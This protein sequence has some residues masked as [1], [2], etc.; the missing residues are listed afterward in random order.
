MAID[1]PQLSALR[2]PVRRYQPLVP[3]AIALILGILAGEYSAPA[4]CRG[5]LPPVRLGC[6]GWCCGYEETAA[7]GCW[8]Q[9]WR[10]LPAPAAWYHG[11]DIDP[12]PD[13]IAQLST[14]YS[15]LVAIEG[16][17]VHSPQQTSPPETFS[18]RRQV[19]TLARR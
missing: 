14:T 15:R 19:F 9:C 13:D 5:A 7:G 11:R 12:A 16:I 3:V 6:C 10:W 4:R 17:L 2:P 8:R 1:G 18:Y